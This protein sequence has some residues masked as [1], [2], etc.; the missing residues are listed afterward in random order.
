VSL[1]LNA[2][3]VLLETEGERVTGAR[4]R[5]GRTLTADHYI[6]A[7]PHHQLTA[8]LPEPALT[9]FA[10]FQQLTRLSDSP[11]LAVHLTVGTALQAPRVV[12][13]ARRTF[14]WL[15]SRPAPPPRG[16]TL[17]SVVATGKHD[18]LER[19][20]QDLIMLGLDEL[21]YAYP[22]SNAIKLLEGRVVRQPQAFLTMSP[23]TRVLRPLPRS[24][25]RNLFVGGDWTDTGLPATLE[26]AIVSGLRCA[27][28]ILAKKD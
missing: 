28:A 1:Q 3:T 25:F 10:Y 8:I 4:L 21:A 19:T 9:H 11:A 18:L 15:V 14:H 17:V 27:E 13:F 26:G 6:V 12:L 22:G 24:P 20:D 7:L 23:G 5:D 2:A 16:G